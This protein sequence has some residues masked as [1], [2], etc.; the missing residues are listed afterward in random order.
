M[1]NKT[2]LSLTLYLATGIW[3]F[4]ANTTLA[5]AQTANLPV[6]LTVENNA[7]VNRTNEPTTVGLPLP[8]SSNILSTNA[9]TVTDS[10]NQPVTAQFSVT[11]R[12]GGAPTDSNRPIKWVLVSFLATVP[13]NTSA[14]Y[15]LTNTT[16]NAVNNNLRV[17]ADT[18]DQLIINTGTATFTIN[19]KK[20]TLF[21]K[22]TVNGATVAQNNNNGIVITGNDNQLY[23]SYNSAPTSVTIN[24]TGPVRLMVT[25][26]GQLKN[27]AQTSLLDYTAYL[28][29]YVNSSTVRTL[30]T[31]GN[32][33][34][35]ELLP[36]CCK[37]DVYNYPGTTAGGGANS[38]TF[39]DAVIRLYMNDTTSLRYVAPGP[40]TTLTGSINQT[41]AAFQNSSGTDYWNRYTAAADAPRTNAYSQ[42]RGYK[43][44]NNSTVLAQGDN[45]AGWLAATTAS[46][47]AVIAQTDF[48]QNFP[49]RLAISQT[50]L[51]QQ[52]FYPSAYNTTYNLRVGEEKTQE[53]IWTFYN[54]VPTAAVLANQGIINTTPLLAAPS[55]SWYRDTGAVAPFVLDTAPLENR[56]GTINS[57][58]TD[59]ERY[60]YYVDR[61]ITADPQFTGTYAT[62]YPFHALWQ[63]S[64]NAPS[65]IDYFNFYGK[66]WY[67]NQPL[68]FEM[69]A[70]GKAGPFDTKYN[71]DYGAWQQY[72]RTND[73][74]WRALATALAK[75]SEQLMLHDVVTA[76][77]Y[78]VYR[79]Q[80]AIF[81]MEQHQETGNVN[82]VRNTLGPVDDTAFGIKGA[83]LYYYLTG[84][85]PSL[86]FATKGADYLYNFYNINEYYSNYRYEN[87]DYLVSGNARVL[88]NVLNGLVTGYRLTGDAKYQ[89]L[90][91]G[92]LDYYAPNQQTWMTQTLNVGC[93]LANENDGRMNMFMLGLYL[94]AMSD[95]ATATAEFGLTNESNLTK[96][97]YTQFV[98]WINNNATL[99]PTGYLETYYYYC[100]NG[101]NNPQASADMVNNWMLLFADVFAQA[102]A[103]TNNQA[104]LTTA[105]RFFQ[106]GTN[107]PAYLHAPLTYSTTK[108]AVNHTTFGNVY[109]YYKNVCDIIAPSDPPITPPLPPDNTN[110]SNNSSNNNTSTNPASDVEP[111]SVSVPPQSTADTTNSTSNPTS[112]GIEIT[113][114]NID[115]DGDGIIDEANTL[116]QNGV[117]PNYVN[118]DPADVALFQQNVIAISAGTN[119]TIN[120][121]YAD[122]AIYNYTIFNNSS[123]K[124]TPVL[125]H[126]QTGYLIVLGSKRL[127][128]V[129]AYTGA[130]IKY[131]KL[132]PALQARA[133]HK[134]QLFSTVKLQRSVL[135]IKTRKT[136]K[137][138]QIIWQPENKKSLKIKLR[139]TKN[140][141]LL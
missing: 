129:N 79:W 33:Q 69:Y 81:G 140:I 102:Y 141:G 12:W 34:P 49:N 19:K 59:A 41:L 20:F 65:A 64:T 27:T 135:R 114:D 29:F 1:K 39:K 11:A 124:S 46:S 128:I 94:Q 72:F 85:P 95:Y 74:R 80:D 50:G 109:L 9:L 2:L 117:D 122:G 43:I 87:Y 77:G 14:V 53:F 63:S 103:Y 16:A 110:N 3:L 24:E 67:G 118:S 45:Y 100:Y 120:V 126:K 133:N 30:I 22:I 88:A 127:A 131:K 113:G 83:Q 89:Q 54:S 10:N 132:Q 18:A 57:L 52:N 97:R 4:L 73:P 28:Y 66:T 37:Y 38:V 92:L 32:H 99:D 137:K 58:T 25:V 107:N 84:Y 98:D 125:S 31:L 42:W 71:F 23:T 136:I 111:G 86:R 8:A 6:P 56:F 75:H 44:T 7:A 5:Q 91:K 119:C 13:A 26:T 40:N 134:R 36:G 121:A 15:Y 115:N 90:A 104:Y 138:F 96:T 112:A 60:Q 108:E 139:S 123:A 62:Y 82:G 47:A 76:T 70:D 21:D 17:T 106:T 61:I 51:L 93:E 48:W 116:A 35:A 78:D 68:D 105:D 55:G 101:A 130:I